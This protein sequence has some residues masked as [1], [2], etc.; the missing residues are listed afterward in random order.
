MTDEEI[1]IA[2]TMI[3]N[4]THTMD[5]CTDSIMKI[6]HLLEYAETPYALV[7]LEQN[8]DLLQDVRDT[9]LKE[10]EAGFNYNRMKLAL[11]EELN[12]MI[13]MNIAQ[14]FASIFEKKFKYSMYGLIVDGIVSE[15]KAKLN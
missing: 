4:D 5:E 2:C 9:M 10:T 3:L 8:K 11:Q 1:K 7:L 13:R 14:K 15:E 6:T 12:P